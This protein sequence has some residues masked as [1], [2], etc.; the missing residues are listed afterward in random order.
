MFKDYESKPIIRKAHQITKDDTITKLK[1]ESTYMLQ[2]PG[3]KNVIFKMHEKHNLGDYVIYG[4]D[5]DIYHC[6]AQTFAERNVI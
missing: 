2:V 1:V 5:N 4:N 3:E 6:D